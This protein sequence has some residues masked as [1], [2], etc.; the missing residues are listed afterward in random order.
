MHS[1]EVDSV[2]KAVAAAG[3]EST[4][5]KQTNK[6]TIPSMQDDDQ[7][8]VFVANNCGLIFGTC[9]SCKLELLPPTSTRLQIYIAARYTPHQTVPHQT[10]PIFFFIALSFF[11]LQFA[12]KPSF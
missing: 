3:H 4:T 10:L 8:S 12:Q 7:W 9:R 11:H 5:Y 6:P 2:K 1:T